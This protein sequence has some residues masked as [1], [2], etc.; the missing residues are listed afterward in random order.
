MSAVFSVTAEI[1][2]RERPDQAGM[3]LIYEDGIFEVS[4]YQ[5]GPRADQL[6]VYGEYKTAGPAVRSLLK[7]NRNRKPIKIY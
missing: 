7:G 4:E 6:H 1:S 5:G 2:T 3:H